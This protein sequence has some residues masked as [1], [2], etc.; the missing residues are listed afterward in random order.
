MSFLKFILII[1]ILISPANANTIYNLIKIPNLEIYNNNSLNGLKYLKASKLFQVGIRDNN[2]S[3]SR[4]NNKTIEEKFIIIKKNLDRYTPNFLNKINLKYIVLCENLSV[5]EI[6]A[7]GFANHK[8]KTII[9]NTKFNEYDL[10][11]IIHHELF[12]IVSDNYND[13]FNKKIWKKFNHLKFNYAKC[14][15]C[16]DRSGL[17]LLKENE[18]FITEYSMSTPSEDMAEVFSFLMNDKK[19]I[20]EKSTKD[21]ILNKKIDFIKKN[22]L[23]VDENFKFN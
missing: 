8:M 22:L 21:Q 7:A 16:L 11:R 19:R 18:G 23:K 14:S 12:H 9:I 17:S 6:E 10:G 4:H 15:T 20:E 5:S 13:Y 3:C 2:V 1:I